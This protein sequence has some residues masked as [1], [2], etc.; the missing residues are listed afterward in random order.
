MHIDMPNIIDIIIFYVVSY[1][2]FVYFIPWNFIM[3]RITP[4]KDLS[5]I[6]AFGC[7]GNKSTLVT[8]L[9]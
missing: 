5:F 1:I 3:A 8:R 2:P 4:I 6:H 7:I 9:K